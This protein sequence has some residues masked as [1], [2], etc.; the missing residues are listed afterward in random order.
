LTLLKRGVVELTLLTREH[1]QRSFLTFGGQEEV[2]DVRHR[3]I[4]VP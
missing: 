4:V 3:A 1:R 2:A